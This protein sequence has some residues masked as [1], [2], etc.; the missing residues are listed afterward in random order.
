MPRKLATANIANAAR[1]DTLP[2]AHSVTGQAHSTPLC[3]YLSAIAWNP[4]VPTIAPAWLAAGIHR[5]VRV[6][7]RVCVDLHLAR[8]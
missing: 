6:C 3:Q 7:A 1:K 8:R 2:H 4:K 5:G